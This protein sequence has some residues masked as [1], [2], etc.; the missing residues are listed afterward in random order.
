MT[1]SYAKFIIY[2]YFLGSQHLIQFQNF[3][4]AEVFY[5]PTNIEN[6]FN[7]RQRLEILSL[8][9]SVG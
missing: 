2:N 9:G 8:W 5:C 4:L 3:S 6:I 1:I 7:Y